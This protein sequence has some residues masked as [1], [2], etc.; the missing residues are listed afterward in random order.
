M[1]HS[2]A[3]LRRDELPVFLSMTFPDEFYPKNL[4]GK[5]C[6]R[7]FKNFTERLK[8][9]F[10]MAAGIARREH[11]QRKSGWHAGEFFPHYHLL[12]WGVNVV[13]LGCWAHRAWFEA[14]GEL[15]IDHL[16]FGVHVTYVQSWA[17]VS[18]Y[19]SKY[20]AKENKFDAKGWGRW[21]G[22]IRRSKLPW[23]VSYK[24]LLS[25]QQAVQLLRLAKRKAHVKRNLSSFFLMT[26]NPEFWFER[27]GDMVQLRI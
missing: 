10:P 7:L 8:Y 9:K 18:A 16:N 1:M 25:N 5:E 6:N 15:S 23:A 21:W 3:Q 13:D 27:L 26:R 12:I 17:G 4:D 2:L 20:I 24:I 19:V 14:C 11:E 22:F